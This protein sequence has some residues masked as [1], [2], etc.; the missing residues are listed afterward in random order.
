MPGAAMIAKITPL[1]PITISTHGA[2][3]RR[4]FVVDAMGQKLTKPMPPGLARHHAARLQDK[5]IAAP[6]QAPA[7]TVASSAAAVPASASVASEQLLVDDLCTISTSTA[8]WSVTVD[9]P[10]SV[11]P[12]EIEAAWQQLLDSI[13]ARL[14]K[15]QVHLQQADDL[16][17]ADVLNLQSGFQVSSIDDAGLAGTRLVLDPYTFGADPLRR[18]SAYVLGLVRGLH[19][20]AGSPA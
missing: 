13:A 7:P 11:R 3:H 20:C 9:F 4:A 14:H 10:A 18:N 19:L 16:R 1:L 17:P 6:A 8:P 15:H 2:P 5:L 12:A